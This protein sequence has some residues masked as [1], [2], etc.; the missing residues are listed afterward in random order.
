[1]RLA[2]AGL[3]FAK[4]GPAWRAAEDY[5]QEHGA[6]SMYKREIVA[7]GR[8][9]DACAE[10]MRAESRRDI[11]ARCG[12]PACR[13]PGSRA[14]ILCHP[15]RRKLGPPMETRSCARPEC[16]ES[17]IALARSPRRFCSHRCAG[18]AAAERRGY[19]IGGRSRPRRPLHGVEYGRPH[20]DR[21]EAE[22]A[23]FADGDP[24]SI[25]GEPMTGDPRLLDLH[26]DPVTGEWA[27]LAHARC[28]RAE[29]AVRANEGRPA[30]LDRPPFPMAWLEARRP[31]RREG[32]TLREAAWRR[33]EARRAA[34][35]Q[36]QWEAWALRS[37]GL[38]WADVAAIMGYSGTGGAYLAAAAH[39]AR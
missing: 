33:G 8:A 11:C 31:P 27:G 26:H 30:D 9:C 3:S 21:R 1:M 2:G 15:C 12:E 25:C 32:P 14:G 36:R 37:A 13:R 28:N 7:F 35:R 34:A 4:K 39:A 10:A 22:V 20:R 23:A 18:L 6:W 29:G 16:P 19:I 5:R 24:C 38:R 17:F